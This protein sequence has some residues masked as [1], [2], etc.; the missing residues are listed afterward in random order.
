[1]NE[2]I[3]P[4][5]PNIITI[6]LIILLSVATI[7]F[8]GLFVAALLKKQKVAYVLY[9]T[10]LI[11]MLIPMSLSIVAIIRTVLVAENI[12]DKDIQNH[13][14]TIEKTDERLIVTS[15]SPWLNSMTYEIITHKNETYYLKNDKG[16]K[17]IKDR[18][19]K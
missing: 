2:I 18:E 10:M 12:A 16:L 13:K 14:Y 4:A 1:M 15:Q 17:E 8:I 6:G 3:N 19:L 7:S 11:T 9:V 5:L